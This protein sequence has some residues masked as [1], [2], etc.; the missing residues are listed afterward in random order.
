MFFIV[1]QSLKSYAYNAEIAANSLKVFK[2][3]LTYYK[4]RKLVLETLGLKYL[5]PISKHYTDSSTQKQLINIVKAFID[6]PASLKITKDMHN[7][8]V[9]ILKS[10]TDTVKVTESCIDILGRIAKN[11]P[12]ELVNEEM[13]EV[14]CDLFICF[15]GEIKLEMQLLELFKRIKDAGPIE[16]LRKNKKI[17]ACVSELLERYRIASTGSQSSKETICLRLKVLAEELL[18]QSI[19]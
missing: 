18:G 4:F 14:Y 9:N 10:S 5:A 3:Y 11:E 12:G 8:L 1:I 2:L 19:V 7:I 13:I 15:K 6:A 16:N 17:V